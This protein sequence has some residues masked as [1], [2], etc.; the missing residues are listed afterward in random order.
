MEFPSVLCGH[1]DRN[2][3]QSQSEWKVDNRLTSSGTSSQ[4]TM[5]DFFKTSR[6]A[7]LRAL[8]PQQGKESSDLGRMFFPVEKVTAAGKKS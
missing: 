8:K 1:F 6:V 5:K 7:H 2:N 3:N 4:K